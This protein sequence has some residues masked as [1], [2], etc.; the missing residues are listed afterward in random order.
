VFRALCIGKN[1]LNFT[2]IS[3]PTYLRRPSSPIL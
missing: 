2:A 3:E 1:V